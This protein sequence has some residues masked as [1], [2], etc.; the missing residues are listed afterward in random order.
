MRLSLQFPLRLGAVKIKSSDRVRSFERDARVRTI[1]L[2]T[3]RILWIP[4]DLIG[5][6]TSRP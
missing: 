6:N 4:A 1:R 5:K 3:L 2:G